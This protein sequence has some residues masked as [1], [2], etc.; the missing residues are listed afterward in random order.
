MRDAK[1]V[2]REDM[3]ALTESETAFVLGAVETVSPVVLDLARPAKAD[4]A[5]L[6]THNPFEGRVLSDWVDGLAEADTRR[7]LQQIR[8]GVAQGDGIQRIEQRVLGSLATGTKGAVER[9]ADD[10]TTIV[11]TA[12]ISFSNQAKQAAYQANSDI[13][14]GEVFHATLDARTTIICASLDGRRFRVGEGPI[15]PLHPNCRSVRIAVLDDEFL[16]SRPM[17]PVTQKQL[18]REFADE[19][20]IK[21]VATR[22]GLPHGFKGDFDAFARKRVRELVGRVPAE[23]SFPDWLARQSV[24]FQDDYLG[25]AKGRIFRQGGMEPREALRTF[26]DASGREMSLAELAQADRAAFASAGLEPSAFLN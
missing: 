16:G 26:L 17:K 20:G 9:T 24:E 19:R 6:V 25:K 11:R 15:P 18:L 2:L 5:A 21:R 14:E 3:I 10:L 8:I 23:T 13:L 12:V 7:M 1:R 22:K 4:L